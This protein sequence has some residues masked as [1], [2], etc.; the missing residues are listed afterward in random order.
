MS[1]ISSPPAWHMVLCSSHNHLEQ[2]NMI[3]GGTVKVRVQEL[4]IIL[5]FLI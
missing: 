2:N 3:E 5:K 4:K 1:H